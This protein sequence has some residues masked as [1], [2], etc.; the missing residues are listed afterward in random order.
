[1]IYFYGSY[2]TLDKFLYS[3]CS[4]FL[5]EN[6]KYD[7]FRGR[8]QYMENKY[9]LTKDNLDY[10]KT[11]DI[12]LNKEDYPIMNYE[13]IIDTIVKNQKKNNYD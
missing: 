8:T 7:L 3:K 1:M 4:N 5:F 2:T 10:V 9:I 13:F 11:K 6:K 12:V